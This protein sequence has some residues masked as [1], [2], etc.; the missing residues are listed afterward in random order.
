MQTMAK[1]VADPEVWKWACGVLG[2]I[3]APLI[4]YVIKDKRKQAR[5]NHGGV[6]LDTRINKLERNQKAVLGRIVIVE[7][8][9]AKG[10]A[11]FQ[12]IMDEM[13]EIKVALAQNCDGIRKDIQGLTGSLGDVSGQ[14][15]VLVRQNGG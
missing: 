1:A 2:A 12:Y 5:K 4:V 15:K 13:G 6:D 3:L 14:L 9:L 11:Q 10:D 7:N 8:R